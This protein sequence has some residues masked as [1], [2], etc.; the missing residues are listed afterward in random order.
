MT[1]SKKPGTLRP[2]TVWDAAEA[3]GLTPQEFTRDASRRGLPVAPTP[4][5]TRPYVPPR[6]VVVTLTTA[7][8]FGDDS[9]D[10]R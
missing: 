9:E 4:H 3:A 8:L 6:R 1:D 10:E 7:E 2:E 5:R